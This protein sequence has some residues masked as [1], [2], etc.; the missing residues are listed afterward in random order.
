MADALKSD[1]NDL[2]DDT[3]PPAPALPA[4]LEDGQRTLVAGRY[5]LVE[6]IAE[7]GM[8]S[9]YV[10]EHTL[11]RKKL[12]LKVVHPYLCRGPQGVERFHREVSAAAEIDHPGIVQVFDAGVDDDGGFFMAMELLKGESL[13]ERLRRKW[14]GTKTAVA[15]IDGMLEPLAKAHGKGFI[16]RDLKPDNVFLAIDE[17]GRERVKLLDFGLARDV[18]KK[19]PTRTGITFGTP[20]YMSPEQ[21]MSAR[22]VR[23]PGDVWA[24]GV[25]LY[26]LLSGEHPFSGETPNAVM[27][28]AI[29]EPLPDLAAKAPHVPAPLITLVERVL[30][31]DPAARPQTAGELLAELRAITSTLALDDVAPASPKRQREWLE[32]DGSSAPPSSVSVKVERGTDSKELTSA[33]PTEAA[34]VPSSIAAPQ[35]PSLGSEELRSVR[36][37][38][39]LFAMLGGGVVIAACLAGLAV[40]IYAQPS[41]PDPDPPD[42]AE[43]T[44][45]SGGDPEREIRGTSGDEPD[46]PSI[47]PEPSAAE[48]ALAMHHDPRPTPPE[49][50]PGVDVEETTPTD[51]VVVAP[52][53]PTSSRRSAAPPG[54]DSSGDALEQ[55]RACV[56]RNNNECAIAA[57]RGHARSIAER[58]MLIGLLQETGHTSEALDEMQAFLRRYPEGRGA[59]DYRATLERFGRSP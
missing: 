57:L 45:P 32:E 15:I 20:E 51:P 23:A 21:A 30:E 54:E 5:R 47:L 38:R 34:K 6:H 25:M 28:N 46:A 40:W 58:G 7:G 2:T 52:V 49:P 56:A 18:D 35:G 29:K 17:E 59:D 22:K 37:R 55:A 36:P 24:V 31:K 16:H 39:S 48:T 14:P 27:A 50:P 8:G 19:G 42:H 12:A 11:S 10:A 26:E 1:P 41:Q 3:V 43:A 4:G 33:P 13:G 9:V 53:R 44:T